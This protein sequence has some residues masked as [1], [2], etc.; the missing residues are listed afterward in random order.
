M[1]QIQEE[2]AYSRWEWFFYMILVPA[3]F[4]SL[5]AGVLLSLLGVDVWGKMTEVASQI[6]YVN[7][8]VPGTDGAQS[9]D[10]SDDVKKLKS[11]L[12]VNKQIAAKLEEEVKKKDETILAM[13]KQ[14]EDLQKLLEGR[15][16]DEEERQQQYAELSKVYTSMSAKNAAAII[17]NLSLEEAVTVLSKMKSDQRASILAKMDPQKAADISILLKDTVVNKDDDIAALQQRLKAL[18]KALSETKPNSTTI[19]ELAKTFEQMQ[20]EDAAGIMESLFRINRD[21]VLAIL[22]EMNNDKRAQILSTI[23][24]HD[25]ENKTNLAA[26]ITEL[27]R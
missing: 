23:S 8:L 7:Q 2:R 21:K 20:P 15:R 19:T 17:E 11:E 22:S 25:E 18:T 6:P 27:L 10:P 14:V 12:T 16:A 1:E 26:T 13:Q 4:A 24:K 3:L 9:A 5:L